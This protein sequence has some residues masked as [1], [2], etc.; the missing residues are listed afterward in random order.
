LLPAH[1]ELLEGLFL[2]ALPAGLL[3]VRQVA[4]FSA[5]NTLLQKGRRIG[6]VDRLPE[7]TGQSENNCW[8]GLEVVPCASG[9]ISGGRI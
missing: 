8:T 4:L 1:D 3:L 5:H 9:P 7:S 6:F 2:T